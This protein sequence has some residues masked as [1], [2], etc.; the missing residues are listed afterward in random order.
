MNF[1]SENFVVAIVEDG[2]VKRYYTIDP[3]TGYPDY[4][5]DLRSAKFFKT[6]REALDIAVSL[7]EKANASQKP[8]SGGTIYPDGDIHRALAMSTAKMSAKGQAVV[9]KINQEPIESV[10]IHGEIKKPKG[11]IY[12]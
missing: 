4:L 11:Y 6:K 10:P 3:S 9:F 5:E 7:G 1:Q 8:L 2:T 12:E